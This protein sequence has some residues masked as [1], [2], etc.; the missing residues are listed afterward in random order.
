MFDDEG[1]QQA[2]PGIS[3][4]VLIRQKFRQIQMM[5]AIDT[6]SS[7][8]RLPPPCEEVLPGLLIDGVREKVWIR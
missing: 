5:V 8:A 6:D 4:D 2:C 7:D 1:L 3:E